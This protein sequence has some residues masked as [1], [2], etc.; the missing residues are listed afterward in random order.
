MLSL[1]SHFL[2]LFICRSEN[3]GFG[4]KLIIGVEYIVKVK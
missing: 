3:F 1:L 2:L 4:K